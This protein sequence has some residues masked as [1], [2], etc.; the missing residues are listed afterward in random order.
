[1][2]VCFIAK[3]FSVELEINCVHDVVL[4]LMKKIT[5][6]SRNKYRSRIV[7]FLTFIYTILFLSKHSWNKILQ[8]NSWKTFQQI[9][10]FV[11]DCRQDDSKFSK[12][13]PIDSFF[14]VFVYLLSRR[15]FVYWGKKDQDFVECELRKVKKFGNIKRLIFL[16]SR[17]IMFSMR[18]LKC[19]ECF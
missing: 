14:F 12:C 18:I 5:S 13:I 8:L 17:I 3:G 7:L 2:F 19:K 15:H 6:S 4:K 16:E 9:I 1:M 10:Y 11:I